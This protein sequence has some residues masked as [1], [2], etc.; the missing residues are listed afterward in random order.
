MSVKRHKGTLKLAPSTA[1][2]AQGTLVVRSCSFS[3]LPALIR[4]GFF[5]IES[6]RV[7]IA[8]KINVKIGRNS[9]LILKN[10]VGP[11]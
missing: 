3:V 7:A 5:S 9:P 6:T 2:L 10:K 11:T 4:V 1:V 8:I